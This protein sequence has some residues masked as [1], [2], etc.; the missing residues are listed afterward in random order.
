MKY[1]PRAKGAKLGLYNENGFAPILPKGVTVRFDIVNSPASFQFFDG[2]KAIS[3]IMVQIEDDVDDFSFIATL[4]TG[5]KKTIN[6]KQQTISYAYAERLE[7]IYIGENGEVLFDDMSGKAEPYFLD[8]KRFKTPFE[9]GYLLHSL[10]G[11]KNSAGKC[12]ILDAYSKVLV[13]DFVLDERD[14]GIVG[15]L[16]LETN[17]TLKSYYIV[18]TIPDAQ[19]TRDK[20]SQKFII[21]GDDGQFVTDF[22]A[23]KFLWQQSHIEKQPNGAEVEFSYSAFAE[24]AASGALQTRILKINVETGKLEQVYEVPLI[25][26]K[27]TQHL[28][29][30][31]LTN[32]NRIVILTQNPE[33]QVSKGAYALNEDGTVETVLRNINTEI[34]YTHHYRKGRFLTFKNPETVGKIALDGKARTFEVLKTEFVDLA[35]RFFGTSIPSELKPKLQPIEEQVEQATKKKPAGGTGP[36]GGSG[37][38]GGVFGG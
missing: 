20:F 8:K 21:V 5:E 16:N 4:R 24:R 12:A 33:F 27:P 9:N 26:D 25:A 30:F 36:T 7:N 10:V 13:T 6:V 23:D 15:A 32:D 37:P 14:Y 19:E 34:D 1:L 11:V 38:N 31:M 2:K 35:K 18:K 22:V 29:S 17:T 3:T 28:G